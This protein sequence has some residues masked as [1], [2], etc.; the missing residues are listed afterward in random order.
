MSHYT[1]WLVVF[2]LIAADLIVFVVP[3]LPLVAVYILFIRPPWFKSFV[4]D[5]YQS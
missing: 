1:P 5:L 2:G 3:I 4:D